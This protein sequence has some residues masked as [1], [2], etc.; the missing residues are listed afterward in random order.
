MRRCTNSTS[1]LLCTLNI[2]LIGLGLTTVGVICWLED[3]SIRS[4]SAVL[5]AIPCFAVLS[6]FFGCVSQFQDG[7]LRIHGA[8]ILASIILHLGGFC[9]LTIRKDE[10][11]SQIVQPGENSDVA[12]GVVSWSQILFLL[13]VFVQVA[14]LLSMCLNGGREVF[15]RQKAKARER[16]FARNLRH[17]S[18]GFPGSTA[19]GLTGP[20]PRRNGLSLASRIPNLRVPGCADNTGAADSCQNVGCGDENGL[21]LV[22][23]AHGVTKPRPIY[24][25]RW[26]AQS[27]TDM[28]IQVSVATP[29]CAQPVPQSEDL[30]MTGSPSSGST[31]LETEK[32]ESTSTGPNKTDVALEF[33]DVESSDPDVEQADHGAASDSES[34]CSSISP[35]LHSAKSELLTDI[36]E[37]TLKMR[38]RMPD[39]DFFALSVPRNCSEISENEL[40]SDEV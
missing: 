23:T 32:S 11:V 5:V 1:S 10:V 31:R 12:S 8:A 19:E 34:S 27:V 24:P 15:I 21:P 17:L 29:P 9:V 14:V 30:G 38:S 16:E 18:G 4:S 6:G 28:H 25:W 7:C 22:T 37:A 36:Q 26:F 13:V 40:S 35:S 39:P 3:G 20:L 2:L 33:E